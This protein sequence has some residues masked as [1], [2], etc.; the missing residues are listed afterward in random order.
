[1]VNKVNRVYERTHCEVGVGSYS[2]IEVL[3]GLSLLLR[4]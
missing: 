2:F 1:M 4:P 3:M